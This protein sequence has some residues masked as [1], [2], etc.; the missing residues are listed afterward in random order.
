MTTPTETDTGT[1]DNRKVEL[2]TIKTV[3]T[4][5]ATTTITTVNPNVDAANNAVVRTTVGAVP[6]ENIVGLVV[7]APIPT[8]TAI[9]NQRVTKTPPPSQIYRAAV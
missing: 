7:N 8:G 6:K 2:T 3:T 1:A 5:A 9:R 4:T